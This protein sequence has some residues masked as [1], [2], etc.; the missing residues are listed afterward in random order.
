MAKRKLYN[1]SFKRKRKGKTEYRGRLK[2]LLSGKPRLIIRKSLKSISAQVAEYN[3]KGDKILLCSSSIHLKKYGW[4]SGFSNLPSAYLTGL[5]IG[6]KALNKGIKE[7]IPDI[8]LNK[9]VM[10]TKI[11]ALLKGT[12]DAGVNLSCSE[13]IFPKEER[14]RG[15]HIKKYA[16]DL[17][18]DKDQYNKKFSDYI[19]NNF[20]PLK[21][22]ENFETTKNKILGE[23]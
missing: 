13:E 8:G 7:L 19:K 15:E 4:K 23:K 11:Y 22:T 9:S 1:L 18:K 20:D 2:L 17:S 5:L 3:E 12:K 10:G 6:K 16:E 14:I 21:I